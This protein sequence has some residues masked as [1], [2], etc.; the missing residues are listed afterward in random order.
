MGYCAW[1]RTNKQLP[2]YIV[3][4]GRLLIRGSLVRGVS[5]VRWTITRMISF[6]HPSAVLNACFAGCF[7]AKSAGCPRECRGSCRPGWECYGTGNSPSPQAYVT[8][9]M[10]K[11]KRV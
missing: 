10:R 9:V 5:C 4:L 8:A 7:R 6:T 2:L 3:T 11:A 1:A